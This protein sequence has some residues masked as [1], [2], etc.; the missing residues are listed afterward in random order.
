MMVVGPP[1]RR[2]AMTERGA[3]AIG[4]PAPHISPHF[5]SRWEQHCSALH[6]FAP[7]HASGTSPPTNCI[8]LA[9]TKVRFHANHCPA[10]TSLE[11]ATAQIPH[12]YPQ[13]GY[14]EL[15]WCGR[16]PQAHQSPQ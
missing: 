8:A 10:T 9:H 13:N 2:F 12:L 3:A 1:I 16:R 7:V 14:T 11:S 4:I 6:L 5:A 15:F